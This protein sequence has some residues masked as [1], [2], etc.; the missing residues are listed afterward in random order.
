M[1]ARAGGILV[2]GDVIDVLLAIETRIAGADIVEL[3]PDRDINGM[4][5]VLA[6]KMVKELAALATEFPAIPPRYGEG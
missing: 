2:V 6:A 3:N 1:S 4:T 5:A